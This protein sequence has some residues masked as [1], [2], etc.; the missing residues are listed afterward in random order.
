MYTGAVFMQPKL[1]T[2]QIAVFRRM[3][4]LGYCNNKRLHSTENELISAT[5]MDLTVKAQ[6]RKPI[7]KEYTVIAFK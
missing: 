6:R 2:I 7:S 3:G 1:H 5:W 4:K